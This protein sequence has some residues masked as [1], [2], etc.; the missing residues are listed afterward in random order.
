[1]CR[2]AHNNLDTIAY[3]R[4]CYAVA[5]FDDIVYLRSEFQSGGYYQAQY[6]RLDQEQ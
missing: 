6:R 4:G 2:P 5:P 1:M 3:D